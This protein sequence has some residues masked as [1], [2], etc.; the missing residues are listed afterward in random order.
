MNE[1]VALASTGRCR[2]RLFFAIMANQW[3]KCKQRQA[4]AFSSEAGLLNLKQ[5]VKASSSQS[6]LVQSHRA[7]AWLQKLHRAEI[8]IGCRN[9]LKVSNLERGP[10]SFQQ[11]KIEAAVR[12][13]NW[14]L[15]EL[16][17]SILIIGSRGPRSNFE[18]GDFEKGQHRDPD[19]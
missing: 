11:A 15:F 12:G 3:G 5:K 16:Q 10:L 17:A 14:V 6:T 18:K 2:L 9:F 8:S 7:S 4:D 19:M 1:E 13:P